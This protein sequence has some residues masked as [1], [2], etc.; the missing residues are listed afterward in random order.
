M[1]ITLEQIKELRSA[2]GAG[3]GI[4]KEAL[5][6]SKGDKEK[7][8]AYLREKGVAK[9]AKRAGN[10][11]DNGLIAHYIHG[12][13]S[14][15]VL[16]ELN[17]ETDFAARNE[18]FG[19]LA[20]DLALHIAAS[21]PEYVRI[22]D[23]PAD[24]MEKEK[25]AAKE[26]IDNKKPAEIVKKIIEGK[27]QKFYTEKVLMEQVFFKDETK[28]IKDLINEAVAVIGEKIEV[29]RFCR[30]QIAGPTSYCNL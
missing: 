29:G 3:V 13:G 2:T 11:A 30:M 9:G 19:A 15:G 22:E 10:R 14:V 6:K 5:E 27:L 4:V 25:E 8:I 20:H 28:K 18:K 12:N 23:I 24:L 16:V 7:A 17:S 21:N 1:E 26:G